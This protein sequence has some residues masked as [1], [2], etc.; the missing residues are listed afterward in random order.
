MRGLQRCEVGVVQAF[1]HPFISVIECFPSLF[2]YFVTRAVIGSSTP[3]FQSVNTFQARK[4]N[5]R[6]FTH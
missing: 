4:E 5:N 3:R 1:P 6:S 2:L